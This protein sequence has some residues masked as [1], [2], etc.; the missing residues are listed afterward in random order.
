MLIPLQRIAD[1]VFAIGAFSAVLYYVVGIWSA[2]RFLRGKRRHAARSVSLHMPSV[3]I[4][5]PVHGIDPGAYESFRSH[6]LQDYPEY[7]IIFVLGE[8]SDPVLPLIEQLQREFPARSI[9]VCLCSQVQGM[10]R[11]VGKLIQILPQ[12]RYEYLIINDGDVRVPPDY[13]RR[14]MQHFSEQRV[15]LVTCLYRGT[16]T[17]T[18][19]SQLE[20]LGI[21]T[22]FVAGV[23]VAQQMEGGLHFGLG[24]TLAVSRQALQAIGGL[25]PL[26]DY[27]ADDYELG[28][29]ITAHGYNVALAD[30]VVEVFVPEYSFGSFFEHQ[31]RWGRTMR[32]CRRGGYTGLILTF[33]MLWAL[34]ALIVSGG[35]AFAWVL[36]GLTICARI[37]VAL[38]VGVGI[39]GARSVLRDLWLLPLRDLIAFAVWIGSY[40]GRTVAWRG[41]YYIL[42]DGKLRPAA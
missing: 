8:A 19:G 12:A 2:T 39:L 24:A 31:L 26:V 18:V 4:L 27:L 42:E 36:F 13:L 9:R 28:A 5:K 21:N 23:L 20:A 7:E 35:G 34:L 38:T 41:K 10:N 40:T 16:P 17:R 29:R 25:E 14:V 3:S 15:G 33:G 22:D 37:A 30:V 32:N 1:G 6:C 11:K